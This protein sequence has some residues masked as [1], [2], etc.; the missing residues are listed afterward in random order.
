MAAQTIYDE[1]LYSNYPYAQTHPD[2]LAAVAALHGLG[3]P[4]PRDC[5]VLELGCGAGGNL[6]AMAVATP[7]I[8]AVGVDLAA[9][10]I[11][12]GRR[13][14]EEIGLDNVELR[15]GDV[16][17]LTEG[18][19]GEF[20]FVIAHGLYAWVPEP[21]RDA[22]LAAAH[23]HLAA[24][25][26]AYVSYNT[27]PGGHLRR[28]LRELGFWFGRGEPDQASRAL[29]AQVLFR[30]L[31]ENGTGSDSWW[32]DLL[33]TIIH[34]LAQG[35]VY[36][37]VH[38]DLAQEWEPVWFA[39]FAERAAGHGLAYVGD[40]DL[41]NL[42]PRR[43][44]PSV[45]DKTRALAGGQRAGVLVDDRRQPP[46]EQVLQVDVADVREPVACR[47]LR[48]VR[49]PHRL[50]V[51]REV[52][53]DEPVD[54][55]LRERVDDRVEQLAPPAVRPRAVLLEEPEQLP[56][57]Q[58]ARRLI[59]L[60]APEPEAELAQVPPEVPARERVVGDVREPVGGQVGVRRR[61][62]GVAG[63]LGHPGVEP[64]GDHEV[65]L[66]ERAFGQV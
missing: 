49:E 16:S 60:A 26:L 5:R 2:R 46:R 44:P 51:L 52:V 30:F 24:D 50:P 32:G 7:G 42:L 59:G 28:I 33:D 19:L 40:V 20:D 38:D 36:R 34:P 17:D 31:E 47:A 61:E 48:E 66:A 21:A 4:N 64:V 1:V 27:Y 37:L 3:A 45:E 58:G 29:R 8:R 25:G 65:E 63:R 12:E 9:V 62:H 56:C 10:P 6:L 39:E 35:D 54:V 14:V 22:V 55:A 23:S 11:E 41:Q 15:Q 13:A 57:P 18:Q 53:V 43:L